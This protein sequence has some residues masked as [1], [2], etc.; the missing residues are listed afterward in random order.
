M[1]RLSHMN[2]L[3]VSVGVLALC[4]PLGAAA[5]TPQ[6]IDAPTAATDPSIDLPADP[7]AAAAQDAGA[8]EVVVTGSRIARST[9]QQPTPIT[10]ITEQQLEQ[11]AATNVV[12]LL[13]DVPALRP[14]RNNGSGR[15]LGLATF[16]MRALGSTRTLLLVDG[17]RVMDS[18]PIANGFDINIL[19]APLI[20]RLDIVTAGASS[21][22]GS[23]A[24]TGVV[25]LILA[26]NVEGGKLD[27][28]YNVSTH[29][30]LGQ[31]SASA[32]YGG[33]FGGN[34]G[35]YL[36]AGSYFNQPDIIYQGARDWGRNGV[37][38]IPNAA[39]TPTNGQ[40]RQLIVPN[41]RYSQM[42]AGGV[43]TS[44]GPLRNIQFGANGAQSIFQ[45][46][47]NVG[48]VWMEG[49]E[50]LMPQ[51]TFAP[52]QVAS[53]QISGFG[54]LSY[55]FTDD[56][57]GRLDVLA[58]NTLARSTGNYNTNNGDITIRRDNAFLPTNIRDAMIANNLTTIRVGR[59]NPEQG[60][61]ENSTENSYYR[62]SGALTGSLSETWKWALG[63]SY[64]YARSLIEGRNNRNQGN[65]AL[66]LD[67]VVGPNGQPVCRSTLTNPGNG[68]VPANIFGIGA[69]TPEVN[70]YV[71][72]TSRQDSRSQ[73]GIAN[74]NVSGTVFDTWA[75]PVKVA[76]GGE[77]RRDS[78]DNRS[79]PV[80][81]VNG[82][83]QGTFGSYYGK[84]EVKEAYGEVSIPL[85]RETGFAR[86]LDLDLA[87]RVVDYSTVGSTA[88]WKA[89]LNYAINDDIR[90]RTT[91]S[92][93]FRAP[94][95]ND[96][97]AQANIRIGT[98][99]DFLTNR[100]ANVNFLIG[101]NPNLG[102][103]TA[104]T[105]TGG[106]VLQPSF[107]PRL[108]LSADF[109]DIDL[110][111]AIITP[112]QQ[113]VVD[114][115]GR[116]D[117]IFC[118]GVLRD[119]TGAITQVN[120]NSFNAQT[121]KTRGVDFEASYAFPLFAG[122]FTTRALATYVDRLVSSTANGQVDTAG[123]LQG[124]FATPKWRGST[125]FLYDQGPLNLR[126]LFN[127]IGPGTFDNA[128]GPL[129]LNRNHYPAYLY[130][131]MSV[132]Y[133]VTDRF[134]IYAKVENLTDTDPPLLAESSITVA[135]ATLSQYHDL[136]GRVVGIGGRIRF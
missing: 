49:G 128:F 135:L 16:N 3:T 104:Y 133:D 58:A 21:V 75:G 39:Y 51:P 32:L 122:T 46:G 100:T 29:G 90:L 86:S 131:D 62:V 127:Y 30:D 56:V 110:R 50:G 43:I 15:N 1:K 36:L 42:T 33:K 68:C 27:A 69:V 55:D 60:R 116:G 84:L 57:T 106:I 132:T 129:D 44:T 96:L 7:T 85:A 26:D 47:T 5:Q 95:I 70:A 20:A 11:K 17:Q 109:Y 72:G 91:Y 94:R 18:S 82:W 13:R 123:Q 89:G 52:L 14:N 54:R 66:A 41:A 87:G 9:F 40:F 118:A 83:R 108:Q 111:D 8:G 115:C 92:R 124:G 77:Y 98:V 38:F 73:S 59:Y 125:T 65:W 93:D 121:L 22:Y 99:T 28:Q 117:Q 64:T 97:F 120:A 112:G 136:R 81:D 74:L 45:Q 63:G 67:A 10:T 134:Q 34:R 4:H 126:L 80:S 103:E 53:R 78:V 6:S 12:D 107:I 31:I 76:V 61:N 119:E 48:T 19:P 2:L 101:G 37:T 130:T 23:D 113:E 24:I 102:P 79:D 88:V 35:R 114:R 105:F 25:N 71:L